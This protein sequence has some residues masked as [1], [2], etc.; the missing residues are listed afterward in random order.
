MQYLVYM[1][2]SPSG[3]RYI[4]ITRQTPDER[5]RKGKGYQRC[6]AFWRAI[7]KYG[8]DNISHEII[9]SC[10]TL[11]EANALEKYYIEHYQSHDAKRGYNC[12]DGGDGV[13]GWKANDEQRRKIIEAKRAMW[14]DTEAREKL[15]AE[16]R[17]RAATPEEH[18]RLNRMLEQNW[19]NP[20]MREKLTKHLREI[21]RSPE[22]RQ[23]RAEKMKRQWAE[24]PEKYRNA[25][26]GMHSPEATQKRSKRM[27]ALWKEKS[28]V[29]LNNRVYKSG[30]ENANSKPIVC[31]ETGTVFPCARAAENEMGVSYK[32]ISNAVRG[33]SKTAGGYHWKFV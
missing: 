2:T 20:Q 5:W 27:K 18:D 9:D 32:S 4:G 25:I 13:A 26:A 28:E 12:T 21:A 10:E 6:T 23:S 31:V 7:Q 33:K 8:W 14:Q 29:F 22:L 15:T 1:H 16:R 17:A 3:K 30:A 19:S 11:E 24:H